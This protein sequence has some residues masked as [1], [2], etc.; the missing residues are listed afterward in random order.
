[1]SSKT[2]DTDVRLAIPV[3]RRRAT[4]YHKITVSFDKI[5]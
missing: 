2:N 3:T 5:T 1:M 4:Q